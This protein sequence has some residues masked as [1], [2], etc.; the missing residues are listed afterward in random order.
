MLAGRIAPHVIERGAEMEGAI[1]LVVNHHL[2]RARRGARLDIEGGV[3]RLQAVE[4]IEPLL[5]VAQIERL[6]LH[7][8]ER[9]RHR[10]AAFALA[11]H[12]DLLDGALHHPD[13]K[14]SF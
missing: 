3:V 2:A 4:L 8:E 7:A 14:L 1:A 13:G 5:E 11:V 6:A 9:A 10:H 12:R